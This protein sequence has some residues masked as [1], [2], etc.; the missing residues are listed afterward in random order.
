M[1]NYKYIT[2]GLLILIMACYSPAVGSSFKTIRNAYP[3]Y[4][5]LS[6]KKLLKAMYRKWG[7]CRNKQE[8]VDETLDR[9]PLTNEASAA[10]ARR[11]LVMRRRA[12]CSLKAIEKLNSS[13]AIAITEIRFNCSIL[14]PFTCEPEGVDI[15]ESYFDEFGKLRKW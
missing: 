9:P 5:D 1:T 6:D 12:E 2:S 13:S 14:F 4:D 7:S 10:K 15:P 11:D 8:Y 3:E